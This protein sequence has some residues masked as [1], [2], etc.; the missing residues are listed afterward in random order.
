MSSYYPVFLDLK[1]KSS[2]IVGGGPVAEGKVGKLLETGAK[3]TVI[4]PR[5]TEAVRKWAEDSAIVWVRREYLDG[6]L[7]GASIAIAATNLPDVNHRVYDEAT[8]WGILVNVVDDPLHCNFIAPSI[9]QRGDV[10]LAISTGGASPAL[11][12][13]LR[14]SLTGSPDFEWADLSGVLSQA[15]R[16]IRATGVSVSPQSWQRCMTPALLELVQ[17]GREQE[18]LESLLAG[19]LGEDSPPTLAPASPS[20]PA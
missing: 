18:A 15:R 20:T 19:L 13:K 4:S 17:A 5:V 11:A 3:I 14:E 7:A 12:R 2:I 10:T 16:Q 9:V 6:D 1:G 8:G